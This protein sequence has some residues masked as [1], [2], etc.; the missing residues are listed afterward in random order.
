MRILALE[1]LQADELDQALRHAL[2]LV[3]RHALDFHSEFDVAAHRAPRKKIERLEYEAALLR[4]ALDGLAVH[5]HFAAV[6]AGEPV[7]YAQERAFAASARPQDADE[8]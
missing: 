7:E 3:F 5:Q 1:P 6:G 8:L 2:A 4:R